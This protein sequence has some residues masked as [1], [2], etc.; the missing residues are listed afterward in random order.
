MTESSR[1][2]ALA[3]RHRALGSALEDW[4][5]MGAAWSYDTDPCD[6]HDAVREAAGLFDVSGLR[7]VHVR[8]TDAAA[9]VDHII[10]RDMTRIP[11]GMS[12]YG[13]I[14]NDKGRICDDAII[15]HEGPDHWLVVHGSGQTMERLTETA[16]GKNV[17]VE[18]DDFLH[19]ISLQGPK[20]VAFL[21]QH[22]PLDLPALA[23]FH[24]KPTEVFG[25][26]CT[27]S[28]TGYSGERGYE[29]FAGADV[30]GDIWDNILEKGKRAGIVPCSFNC[31]DK[32]RVEAGLLFYPY[33]MTTQNSPWEV[34]LGWAVHRGK[35]DFRGKAAV[36][37]LEGQEKVKVVGLVLDHTEAAAGGEKLE[38]NGAEVGIVNS[39]VWSHRMNKSLALAHIKP[40]YTAPGTQ[41]QVE[42][43]D[44]SCS[45]RV[46]T[47][48]FYDPRKTRTHA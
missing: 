29:I 4:N 25:H 6:E 35:A 7:K 44:L 5:G 45:A 40:E 33:D 15:A 30:I 47:L 20:A 34:G 17:D 23:Y 39:P 16:S 10:T 41:L 36:L 22:T 3:G 48:P 2:S 28:R 43:D 31:L 14:L 27:I 21:D 13:P 37:A 46:E 8:G 42:G 18:F 9:V 24:Q 11:V 12:A 1:T 26:K 19:D 38:I 32:I